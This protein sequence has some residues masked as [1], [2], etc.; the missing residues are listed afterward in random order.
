MKIRTFGKALILTIIINL[1]G[2]RMLAQCD[3]IASNY[4]RYLIS[5][6]LN[7]DPIEGMWKAY[8]T[9]RV[10]KGNY[11]KR[12]KKEEFTET[13]AI[14]KQDNHFIVCTG[15]KDLNIPEIFFTKAQNLKYVFNKNYVKQKAF[16]SAYASLI[17]EKLVFT[18]SENIAYLMELLGPKFKSGIR[19]EYEY[20]MV[21][22]SNYTTKVTNQVPKI[23]SF[24]IEGIKDY[25]NM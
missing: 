12:T 21:K 9:V 6:S 18:Y 7:L 22:E 8:R 3:E 13:W 23:K 2:Y 10:Y 17:G 1:W 24:I 11:L 5:H 25:F 14:L 15:N 4:Q 19:V 16:V 20:E